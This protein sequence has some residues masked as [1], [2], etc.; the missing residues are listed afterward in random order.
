MILQSPAAWRRFSFIGRPF[1]KSSVIDRLYFD[2]MTANSMM[3]NLQRIELAGAQR[4]ADS[5]RC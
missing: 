5:I 2:V 1:M 4:S 3:P